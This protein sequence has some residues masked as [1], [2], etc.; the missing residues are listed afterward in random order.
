ML[1]K[2]VLELIER[3]SVNFVD[4]DS[5]SCL[6]NQTFNWF[7]STDMMPLRQLERVK[8]LNSECPRIPNFGNCTCEPERMGYEVSWTLHQWIPG[9]I[10]AANY[11]CS[12]SFSAQVQDG[13]Q[14]LV[15]AAK[16][17]CSSMGLTEV[18]KA[19]PMMTIS[20]NISNNSVSPPPLMR[21][22]ATGGLN[23][24]YCRSP[25]WVP[26][27]WIQHIRSCC[28]CTLT[29]I[30]SH[31]CWNWRHRNSSNRSTPSTCVGINS[32]P[33]RCTYCRIPWTKSPTDVYS[34]SRAINCIATAIRQKR[35]KWVFPVQTN[36]KDSNAFL[37]CFGLQIWLIARR[38][39]I[40]DY[41]EIACEN[42]AQ[43]VHELSEMKLCQSPHDWTDYIYYLITLEVLLLIALIMKVTYDWMIFKSAGY[44]PWPAS[45]MPK[46]PCD[47]LCETWIQ[48]NSW[49]DVGA[50]QRYRW[51]EIITIETHDKNALSRINSVVI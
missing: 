17:D 33:F 18:P 43:N 31:R 28:A 40:P 10:R 21:F 29:T 39:H 38:S 37:S 41:E 24:F 6:M 46:L 11:W 13:G 1:C 4:P 48:C 25:A 34:I 47:C 16:V 50:K 8:Q 30:R 7:N 23:V 5:T 27:M 45:K 15:F 9:N 32:K 2:S 42:M 49:W 12:N 36:A 3:G 14:Q 22:E 51:Q 20:L 26:W 35:W 19:L 44:L